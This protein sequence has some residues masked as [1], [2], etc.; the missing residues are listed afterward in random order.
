MF[1]AL[2]AQA[3]TET[4]VMSEVSEGNSF[5]FFFLTFYWNIA[6]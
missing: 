5:F 4:G 6:D 1:T 2:A 3:D